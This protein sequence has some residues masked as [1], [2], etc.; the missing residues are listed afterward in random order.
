LPEGVSKEGFGPQL[1]A[2][3]AGCTG[4][5][6]LSRRTTQTLMR[7]LFGVK[8]SLGSIGACEA[9]ASI[10]VAQPVDDARQYVARQVIANVD[11]TCWF[12]S[13]RHATLWTMVT[14][15]ATVFL[16]TQKRDR[17]GFEEVR[18]DFLGLLG[19]DR[20]VVYEHWPTT[21]RQLCWAHLLR[22]FRRMSERPG[23]SKRVGA[24]LVSETQQ[25]FKWWHERQDGITT[26]ETFLARMRA[27]IPHVEG[28]LL[29]AANCPQRKTSIT[30]LRL[31]EV[32]PALW[33]FA[34]CKGVE[35]TNNAAE[36]ALR[37]AVLWRKKSFGTHS[38][39]GSR[40]AE[41]MLTCATTLRQQDR[42]V[43]DFLTECSIAR[44]TGRRPPSLCPSPRSR[45]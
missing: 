28:L 38:E 8:M 41:R 13:H 45:A 40:F 35:P 20:G 6:Q 5:Y 39:G 18:G 22:E 25:M 3:V 37:P 10:A 24:A 33:T 27:H 16:I 9:R 7:D 12:V 36:R 21:L 30:A 29:E 19:S 32:A 17:Q 15:M 31:L 14:A 42:N 4:L 44:R 11:E 26:D 34:V 1:E 23:A 43:I 2:I